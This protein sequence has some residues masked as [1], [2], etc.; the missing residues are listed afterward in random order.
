MATSFSCFRTFRRVGNAR[1]LHTRLVSSCLVWRSDLPCKEVH[2][3]ALPAAQQ[4]LHC[5]VLIVKAYG[6]WNDT[7]AVCAALWEPRGWWPALGIKGHPLSS[8]LLL[9]TFPHSSHWTWICH[10][11]SLCR[12]ALGGSVHMD[13]LRKR[14][15]SF[16]GWY[17][18][19]RWL[20][21]FCSLALWFCSWFSLECFSS[22]CFHSPAGFGAHTMSTQGQAGCDPC[23]SFGPFGILGK[24]SKWGAVLT[25]KSRLSAK[26]SEAH[27]SKCSPLGH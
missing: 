22:V 9:F 13:G 27:I 3:P 21:A 5:Q 1:R 4:C 19:G 8:F 24:Y 25:L 17:G 6:Q 14:V 12:K 11:P 7:A 2:P 10:S 15:G 16:P 23:V 26:S 20:F 18:A